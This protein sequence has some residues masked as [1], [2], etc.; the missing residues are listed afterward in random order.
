MRDN[1]LNEPAKGQPHSYHNDFEQNPVLQG[2]QVCAPIPQRGVEEAIALLIPLSFF[3][4]SPTDAIAEINEWAQAVWSKEE[5]KKEVVDPQAPKQ[6]AA[7]LQVSEDERNATLAMFTYIAYDVWRKKGQRS[8]IQKELMKWREVVNK[9]ASTRVKPWSDALHLYT[10][11]KI[12]PEFFSK[13]TGEGKQMQQDRWASLVDLATNHSESKAHV[14]PQESQYEKDL[15]ELRNIGTPPPIDEYFSGYVRYQQSVSYLIRDRLEGIVQD[16]KIYGIIHDVK[17]ANIA[18]TIKIDEE[19][20]TAEKIRRNA[21]KSGASLDA[22]ISA[23]ELSLDEIYALQS[24]QVLS[25]LLKIKEENRNQLIELCRNRAQRKGI[26]FKKEIIDT[27]KQYDQ[28]SQFSTV[29][30]VAALARLTS[31]DFEAIQLVESASNAAEGVL[32]WDAKNHNFLR[33]EKEITALNQIIKGKAE[34]VA[35][36]RALGLNALSADLTIIG[37]RRLPDKTKLAKLLEFGLTEADIIELNSAFKFF[38][39]ESYGHEY[40]YLKIAGSYKLTKEM[41]QTLKRAQTFFRE[42]IVEGPEGPEESRAEQRARKT[43][44]IALIRLAKTLTR[45]CGITAT[46]KKPNVDLGICQSIQ[47]FAKQGFNMDMVEQLVLAEYA[48]TKAS[49]VSGVIENAATGLDLPRIPAAVGDTKPENERKYTDSIKDTIRLFIGVFGGPKLGKKA[50]IKILRQFYHQMYARNLHVDEKAF[51]KAV[52][53][54]CKENCDKGRQAVGLYWQQNI[55]FKEHA[56]ALC[57]KAHIS[58]KELLAV[59]VRYG[60]A[61]ESGGKLHWAFKIDDINELNTNIA[62]ARKQ[63]FVIQQF[64]PEID[65]ADIIYSNICGQEVPNIMVGA[66]DGTDGNR[67]VLPAQKL[68]VA[69]VC[70]GVPVDIA[71]AISTERISTDATTT[72]AQTAEEFNAKYEHIKEIRKLHPQAGI[73]TQEELT[74]LDTV[75]RFLLPAN[76]E[77]TIINAKKAEII[78]AWLPFGSNT[79]YEMRQGHKFSDFCRLQAQKVVL[80]KLDSATIKAEAKVDRNLKDKPAPTSAEAGLDTKDKAALTKL[81]LQYKLSIGQVKAI[82]LTKQLKIDRCA[83]LLAK[84]KEVAEKLANEEAKS[85][86]PDDFNANFLRSYNSHFKEFVDNTF[87]QSNTAVEDMVSYAK[88][89]YYSVSGIYEVVL[90]ALI[91]AKKAGQTAI[92]I[93]KVARSLNTFFKYNPEISANLI[94]SAFMEIFSDASDEEAAIE[95]QGSFTPQALLRLLQTTGK[96]VEQLTGYIDTATKSN[97]KAYENALNTQAKQMSAVENAEELWNFNRS[98][99]YA[100][101][102][103]INNTIRKIG[104]AASVPAPP[105]HTAH[106]DLHNFAHWEEQRTDYWKNPAE[107]APIYSALVAADKSI[108]EGVDGVWTVR[109]FERF[110]NLPCFSLPLFDIYVRAHC[111]ELLDNI[112]KEYAER[113]GP[114]E[115]EAEQKAKA[116]AILQ[117]TSKQYEFLFQHYRLG[118][119]FSPGIKSV[120]QEIVHQVAIA[121]QR[122]Y[123][124]KT[125]GQRNIDL[126]K[127]QMRTT[128][129]QLP[130][131]LVGLPMAV[132]YLASTGI[133]GTYSVHKRKDF[134]LESAGAT[135]KKWYYWSMAGEHVGDQLG[136]GLVTLA[137]IAL[138]VVVIGCSGLLIKEAFHR[139]AAKAMD[140]SWSLVWSSISKHMQDTMLAHAWR[141][142]LYQNDPLMTV[143]QLQDLTT[144][145][146]STSNT[147]GGVSIAAVLVNVLSAFSLAF[148]AAS[149]YSISSRYTEYKKLQTLKGEKPDRYVTFQFVVFIP[150]SLVPLVWHVTD[151]SSLMELLQLNLDAALITKSVLLLCSSGIVFAITS[152]ASKTW[153]KAENPL[154]V[155]WDNLTKENKRND[156]LGRPEFQPTPPVPATQTPQESGPVYGPALPPES[157]QT[158]TAKVSVDKGAMQNMRKAA[159]GSDENIQL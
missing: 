52:E 63:A 116:A 126:V 45:Q 33:I 92:T 11:L 134:E 147:V 117:D 105:I 8:E 23:L 70:M 44:L 19:L 101:E 84:A 88:G 5:K 81:A 157:Q 155:I 128:L 93:A 43:N 90:Q 154:E 54:I 98:R 118:I 74:L 15:Q 21:S 68:S 159:L 78:N 60:P 109:D 58:Y 127:W 97:R 1:L 66:T 83:S 87:G 142:L 69:L 51:H 35:I 149:L 64:M 56:D 152:S 125:P 121:M 131:A 7:K 148:T 132:Y 89:Q 10:V 17:T 39:A 55:K 96:T 25:I 38:K 46:S 140:V 102:W 137:K 49:T 82:W 18:L 13:F 91:N 153:S 100:T 71:E 156:L 120:K 124:F 41:L 122:D 103:Q 37:N 135:N 141:M 47:K 67:V 85:Q 80:H 65:V 139:F 79:K 73:I 123:E 95:A 24:V 48:F 30:N 12:R 108:E 6:E 61:N 16:A 40:E 9:L 151:V 94:V 106:E 72:R 26:R 22:Q 34:E 143:G 158:T 107:F 36:R 99:G 110:R 32:D 53:K 129:S 57:S 136:G 104:G 138:V 112:I 31:V 62:K 75:A 29:N 4:D 113:R 20:K 59:D 144:V 42:N 86:E 146:V 28:A 2:I 27:L 114:G 115:G 14:P 111:K 150:M 76:A 145:S 77:E 3:S 50:A 133:A 130:K 119:Y